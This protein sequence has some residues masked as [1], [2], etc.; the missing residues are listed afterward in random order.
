VPRQCI[1]SFD[2]LAR[3]EENTPDLEG[4]YS[5]MTSGDLRVIASMPALKQDEIWV[6]NG[7]SMP[8]I[9]RLMLGMADNRGAHVM[10]DRRDPCG[11]HVPAV[12][13]RF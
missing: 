8:A 2:R 7:P 13:T 12:C 1:C 9:L 5:F 3:P 11:V 6:L 4:Y 10:H